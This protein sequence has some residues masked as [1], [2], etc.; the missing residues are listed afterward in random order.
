MIHPP[1]HDRIFVSVFISIVSD[2][3][4]MVELQYDMHF[5]T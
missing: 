2:M 1:Q 3:A 4:Y 5:C